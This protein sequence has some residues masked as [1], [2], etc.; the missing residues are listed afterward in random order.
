MSGLMSYPRFSLAERHRRWAA[1]R[2]HMRAQNIDVIVLPNNTGHSADLQSNSR[3]LS[4]VGG[5]GD[6]DIAVIFPLE[7]E[8]TAIATS[9]AP[10]WPMVQEWTKDVREARRRFGK[11]AAER[12]K[13][14][15]IETGRIGITGLGGGTRSPEGTISH[16]FWTHIREGLPHAEI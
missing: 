2:S 7:G 1:V 14:L 4:H 6:A 13:E 9:A 3:Y 11:I 12:L 16:S 5:G 15:K 8:I 10:R